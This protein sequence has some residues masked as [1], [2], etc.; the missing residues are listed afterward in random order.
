MGTVMKFSTG[1]VAGLLSI[2]L[3]LI[4]A[5]STAGCG[6]HSQSV[7]VKRPSNKALDEV[8]TQ[9]WAAEVR[10]HAQ[11]GDWILTRSYTKLSDAIVLLTS[12]DEFSHGTIYDAKRDL[13]IEAV[14]TGVQEIPLEQLVRR[15]NDLMIVRPSVSAADRARAVERARSKLGV[16]YDVRGLVGVEDPDKFYCSELVY[17]S[18]DPR[19][20][21]MDTPLVISPADLIRAGQVVWYSGSRADAHATLGRTPPARLAARPAAAKR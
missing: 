18:I 11:Q 14:D 13:I 12:G 16:P 2:V 3:A 4:A 21:G 1:N 15:T 5:A 7:M 10:L 19:A 6:L 8:V 20:H 17:W 9:R